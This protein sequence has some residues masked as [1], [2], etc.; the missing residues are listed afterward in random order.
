[1]IDLG[2]LVD[3]ARVEELPQLAGALE[4]A[5]VRLQLRL[6]AVVAPT[7]PRDVAP[8]LPRHVSVAEAAQALG[9][10]PGWLYHTDDLPFV[11]RLGRRV[12]V[13]VRLAAEWL[14]RQGGA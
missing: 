11:R 7:A 9:V 13:D 4:A 14:K 6:V 12:V 3:D 2:Q 5:R 8:P 1:V 10:S